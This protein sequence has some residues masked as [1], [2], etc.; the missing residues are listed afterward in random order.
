MIVP[1][2]FFVKVVAWYNSK[3]KTR[4][5]YHIQFD[6]IYIKFYTYLGWTFPGGSVVKES[7]CQCRRIRFDPW[8]GKIPWCR[9]WQLTP[10]FLLGKFH[11]CRSLGYIRSGLQSVHGWKRVKHDWATEPTQDGILVCIF[12][13]IF[14]VLFDFLQWQYYFLQS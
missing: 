3:W 13:S 4:K 11:G 14:S 1:K 2:R 7:A 6:S 12:F 5:K 8:V 10:V 9:K